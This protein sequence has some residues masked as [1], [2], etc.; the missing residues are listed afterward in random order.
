MLIVASL[1]CSV[2]DAGGL[3]ADEPVEP[4][5]IELGRPVDFTQDVYPILAKN[6][7]SCHNVSVPEGS[8]IAESVEGLLAGGDSGPAIVAEQPDES[9]L[10]LYASRSD[11]PSMPPLPNQVG[12]QALTSTEL[13][14]IR[15]W[16]VEGAH[17]GSQAERSSPVWQSVPAH[18]RAIQSVAL[19][20]WS[21]FVAWGRANQIY[22]LDR[23][24]SNRIDRLVDPQLTAITV[25]DQPMYPGGA[26]HRDLVH[27]M[28]FSP[29]GSR[30]ASGGYR[31]VKLWQ[32]QVGQRTAQWSLPTGVVRLAVSDDGHWLAAATEN[33]SIEVREMPFHGSATTL[34]GH[35]STISALQFSPDGTRLHSTSMDQT[36]RS[37]DIASGTCVS[38]QQ[39]DSPVSAMTLIA[40]SDRIATGHADGQ[41]RI[42]TW[43]PGPTAATTTDAP[44]REAPL[45]VL[46]GHGSSVTA[47][48]FVPREPL[49]IVSGGD[50]ST[51]RLWDASNGQQLLSLD[52]G[53]AVT[54]IAVRGTDQAIVAATRHGTA[55]LW[56]IAGA[57]MTQ[58]HGTL[59]LRR[60]VARLQETHAVAE[61]QVTH[62]RHIVSVREQELAALQGD[63]KKT[64]DAKTASAQALQDA[65]TAAQQAS[66]SLATAREQLAG[67]PD[68]ADLQKQV[69]DAEGEVQA[70][71]AAVGQAM[72]ADRSAEESISLA[73][74]SVA[75]GQESL[76]AAQARLSQLEQHRD[77]VSV[78]LQQAQARAAAPSP[79]WLAVTFSPD[80]QRIVTGGEEPV[81]HLWNSATG[82]PLDTIAGHSGPIRSLHFLRAGDLVSGS[83]DHQVAVCSV[84]SR[85]EYAGSLGTS[86]SDPLDTS[87]SMFVDRV[88]TLDFS[89]DG[90]LLATGGGEPSRSGELMLWDVAS[91]TRVRS[92]VD[93]HSDTICGLE[94]SRNDDFL[95]TGAADKFVKMFDVATGRE[96]KSFEGHTHHVLDV[97]WK[98]DGTAVASAGADNVIKYWNT[99]T[100]EQIQSIDG[101]GKQVTSVVMPGISDEL[102]SCSGDRSVRLYTAGDGKHQRNFDGGTDYMYSVTAA[103]DLEIVVSGGEDGILRIWNGRD[104][105]LLQAIEEPNR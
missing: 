53:G 58:L 25:D 71:T 65:Q 39:T 20:P 70:K 68:N 21:R 38:M 13:G 12:A 82:E 7:V 89:S 74:G 64:Q 81:L 46:S 102:V 93:A 10:F 26:A 66:A 14:L 67:S 19:S 80:G 63:L 52:A 95:V 30:L 15:Q 57:P 37:W 24:N 42:W 49:T 86:E 76:A 29:D 69:S 40:D 48:A 88:L 43:P 55:T 41:I 83:S 90:A 35:T 44:A 85:W 91:R 3:R 56:T 73:E 59:S 22:L 8:L 104:G 92:F 101:F 34:V 36:I 100:G 23:A 96:V 94:F 51:V 28:A 47:L 72:A 18:I 75:K 33:N 54:A 11:E 60:E 79:P 103:H 27:A 78:G 97:S 32:R 16:I 50:D 9:L 105:S 98:A 62:S 84:D 17:P 2:R 61:Q 4:A 5:A 77:G 99:T 6:C 31:V 45:L 1:S 87:H